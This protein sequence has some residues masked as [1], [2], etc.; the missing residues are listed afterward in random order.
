LAT[1]LILFFTIVS[2]HRPPLLATSNV[3]RLPPET[4]RLLAHVA[5]GLAEAPAGFIVTMGLDRST[6]APFKALSPAQITIGPLTLVQTDG[7][8]RQVCKR[9][10]L[11]RRFI[12]AMSERADGNPSRLLLLLW[13]LIETRY[14]VYTKAGWSAP[15]DVPWSTLPEDLH[16]EVA[17]RIIDLSPK[18]ANLVKGISVGTPQIDLEMLLRLA[19]VTRAQFEVLREENNDVYPIF[20]PNRIALDPFVSRSIF[21]TIKERCLSAAEGSAWCH[22]I[23]GHLAETRPSTGHREIAELYEA[24]GK[25]EAAL[26]YRIAASHRA[27]SVASYDH[28]AEDLRAAI[29]HCR[30]SSPLHA[31]LLIRLADLQ[32]LTGDSTAARTSIGTAIRIAEAEGALKL[33]ADAKFFLAG[34]ETSEGALAEGLVRLD[35]SLA[36]YKAAGRCDGQLGVLGHMTSIYRAL[37]MWS[38]SDAINDEML[39]RAELERNP[40]RM[41]VSRV[42]AAIS[43][44]VRGDKSCA[45]EHLYRALRICRKN[46]YRDLITYAL[47]DFADASQSAGPDLDQDRYYLAAVASARRH[48][49][50]GRELESLYKLS[51]AYLRANAHRKVRVAADQMIQLAANRGDTRYRGD[52]NR[53]PAI[54]VWKNGNEEEAAR[55]F[56]EA[57]AIAERSDDEGMRARSRTRETSPLP[58]DRIRRSRRGVKPETF[59]ADSENTQ[60]CCEWIVTW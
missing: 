4:A 38:Q 18:A 23:A 32:S 19:N 15:T 11:N 17:V 57:L 8:I 30:Q 7:L 55:L 41:A 42:N 37:R 31:R 2:A 43:S 39:A 33:E 16:A 21:K 49:D 35:Q 25:A 20:N 48:F 29:T 26:T 3:D 50:E 1:E 58:E 56:T 40:L 46:G 9:H 34:L 51:A 14:L 27:K 52:A 45:A 24:A 59:F 44:A 13:Y 53:I 22:R 47:I 10:L 28:A 54:C 6:L 60:K 12:N 36:L 5:S